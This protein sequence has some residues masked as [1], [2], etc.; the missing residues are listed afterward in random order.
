MCQLIVE[1]QSHHILNTQSF[2]TSN[3]AFS[4]KSACAS[5]GSFLLIKIIK[6]ARTFISACFSLFA[7]CFMSS[8]SAKR[9][10]S[11]SL[12]TQ[13]LSAPAAKMSRQ[14][15]VKGTRKRI[16]PT[17]VKTNLSKTQ[18]KDVAKIA[19][20]VVQKAAESK[21]Y[22]TNWTTLFYDGLLP[23]VNPC[24]N[25]SQNVTAETVL[26][27]K[28]R[29]K[30]I[31]ISGFIYTAITAGYLNSAM[32]RIMVIHSRDKLFLANQSTVT[33]TDMFR[34]GGS[35]FRPVDALDNH[36][37]TV[38]SDTKFT[39]EPDIAAQTKHTPF[40]IT[41]PINK[42]ETFDADGSG[43]FKNGQ[44]FVVMCIH[45]GR[46]SGSNYWSSKFNT[47]VNFTDI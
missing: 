16:R 35:G 39:I 6:L 13:V 36:K 20:S 18:A 28:I 32:A 2:N 10:R 45:D 4:A 30:N 19:R 23:G 1:P 15:V 17:K 5:F 41:V 26:G 37:I 21:S 47:A 11:N 44:Y 14:P 24:Y 22:Y 43:Y 46:G 7:N 3:S 12:Y 40:M 33:A 25:M 31:Q 42:T 38:L 8:S 9:S 34:T 27:E 29:L